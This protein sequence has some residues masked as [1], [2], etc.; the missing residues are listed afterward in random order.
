MDAGN[1]ENPL[2]VKCANFAPPLT[3]EEMCRALGPVANHVLAVLPKGRDTWEVH[4]SQEGIRDYLEVEGLTIRGRHL[5]ISRRFPGG[6]CVRIRGIPLN[7]PN[8]KIMSKY[9][10]VVVE[11]IHCTWRNTQI[12]TIALSRSS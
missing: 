3:V 8:E 6:T 5:E 10:D 7:V 12:K 1:Y 11:T 9:G 4:V 2:Y